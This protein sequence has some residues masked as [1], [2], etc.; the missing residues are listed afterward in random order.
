[1]QHLENNMEDLFKRAG[2][3]YSPQKGKGDWETIAKRIAGKQAALSIK[4]PSA[5]RSNKKITVF[6]MLLLST[7]VDLFVIMIPTSDSLL[8]HK[9]NEIASSANNTSDRAEIKKTSA[10]IQYRDKALGLIVFKK[11]NDKY[12]VKR[13]INQGNVHLKE[14]IIEKTFS[15]FKNSHQSD[16][17]K[18]ISSYNIE[19]TDNSEN[20][21]Y[22]FQNHKNDL[23][24]LLSKISNEDTKILEQNI[25]V[26][27]ILKENNNSSP[28]Q[29]GEK[30]TAVRIQKKTGLYFGL[31]AST[32]VSKVQSS[33]FHRP[34]F[35]SG[36]LAGLIVN[37]KLSIETGIILNKKNYS[38]E[39]KSF[40]ID[41]VRSAMP[42]GMLITNLESQ[43]SIIEIPIKLKYNF[44]RK[45]S[46]NFFITGGISSYIMTR[47]NNRYN[48]TLNGN[49]EKVSGIYTK[50]NYGIPAAANVSMGYE[51]HVC[52]N[53]N[54]RL[55]P[56][57]KVPLKGM[58]IG[59]LPLTST[60]LQV[61]ITR[62]FR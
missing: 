6:L 16:H 37:S 57:L 47:E 50:N 28:L 14:K 10:D 39:G 22:A 53:M 2:E 31:I 49:D 42:A 21:L 43:S 4:K 7:V 38:S 8:L 55:E 48:V 59:S 15:N 61:G 18:W 32:D 23:N 13:L 45:K 33:A 52:R 12:K 3:N 44:T 9:G 35:G 1:M 40:S 19:K 51:H 34:G 11:N 17:E 46:S 24:A 54:I 27:G 62:R 41:K 56:F 30:K 20:E 5:K 58:G 60:G 29:I 26:K 25:P 36:V